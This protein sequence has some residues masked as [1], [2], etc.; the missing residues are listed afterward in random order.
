MRQSPPPGTLLALLLSTDERQSL[1]IR[2]NLAASAVYVV[3]SVLILYGVWKHTIE[4]DEGTAL[5]V[6]MLASCA[7]FYIA[8]RA[9]WNQRFT[10]PSLTLPQ[11]LA[12]LTW[13]SCA[14]GI[15]NQAH[16]GMLMPLA[17]VLVFGVFNMRRH[18]AFVASVYAL[19]C[20]GTVMLYKAVTDPVVYPP[21][22]Q[23]AFFVMSMTIVPTIA[24]VAASLSR[25]RQRI[26]DQKAQLAAAMQR[27]A[28]SGEV[29]DPDSAEANQ[30]LGELWQQFA[31][32]A[33]HRQ[34]LEERR[35]TI[36]AAIS[37]DLRSPLGR[38]RMAAEL[39]PNVRGVDVRREA[40]VR[41]VEVVNRLLS[42]F[43]DLAR[44]DHEPINGYVNLCALVADVAAAMPGVQL[45][46][47]PYEPQWLEPANAVLLERAVRNLIDNSMVHGQPPVEVGLRCGT[48]TVLWVRDHGAGV[49]LALHEYILQP[50]TRGEPNR[51]RPGTGLG[52]AVVYRTVVRHGGRLQL[53]DA[54]PGL[55]VE[56][57]LP[58][59]QAGLR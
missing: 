34:D 20:I 21:H 38:I 59:C 57:E 44:T 23:G 30:E 56:M 10:D 26:R 58:S 28:V 17:L 16:G 39:L 42:S 55:R 54:K 31:E 45:V 19:L 27:F 37:H 11:I 46:E 51:L 40:I 49:D 53:L 43:I 35:S 41:N 52:L 25:M 1:R 22:I 12:A 18:H 4:S 2:R 15:A 36:L 9:G 50:F 24:G 29:P 8:L 47:L 3:C 6:V 13:S 33:L 48:T 5:V 32:L 14:Y 7:L